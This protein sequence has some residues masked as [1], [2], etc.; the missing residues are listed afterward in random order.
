MRML[1]NWMHKSS[2]DI[3]KN[4]A[5][6]T[7][8]EVLIAASIM[9]VVF[10]AVGKLSLDG[11]RSARNVES[12]ADESDLRMQ[13]NVSLRDPETCLERIQ[14]ANGQTLPQAGLNEGMMK[15]LA[16]TVG[17][18]EIGAAQGSLALGSIRLAQA[19]D[20]QKLEPGKGFGP[21]VKIKTIKLVWEKAADGTLPELKTDLFAKIQ[22]VTDRGDV[23]G[24]RNKTIELPLTLRRADNTDNSPIIGCFVGDAASAAD[25]SPYLV[26]AQTSE[27]GHCIGTTDEPIRDCISRLPAAGGTVYIKSGTYDIQRL[28]SL[29]DHTRL[30][31]SR[32]AVLKLGADLRVGVSTGSQVEVEDIVL[33]SSRVTAD[34]ALSLLVSGSDVRIRNNRFVSETPAT[35][36][37]AIGMNGGVSPTRIDISS[38]RF[39]GHAA[40][41]AGILR[42]TPVSGVVSGQ[43]GFVSIENNEFFDSGSGR[44]PEATAISL[45]STSAFHL[46]VKNNRM[47]QVK[48]GVQIAADLFSAVMV[49]GNQVDCVDGAPGPG[50]LNGIAGSS[51]LLLSDR[52]EGSF[53]GDSYIDIKNNQILHCQTG[54][55]AQGNS[56]SVVSNQL[57]I[58]RAGASL[59]IKV[60][61]SG[62]RI[63]ANAVRGASFGVFHEFPAQGF[64]L[65]RYNSLEIESNRLETTADRINPGGPECGR[66]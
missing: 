27:E 14:T 60:V 22:V 30:I 10:L 6:M 4:R 43:M 42:S 49:E 23:A 31:G 37:S 3:L 15:R 29:P 18:A 11:M 19:P 47:S 56:I 32:D 16:T 17:G 33:D 64:G 24:L 57:L 36:R 20:S 66:T 8:V 59:G 52:S 50:F 13:A 25:K 44:V 5:G 12:Q 65:V 7:I 26:V 61:G 45:D 9:T 28:I 62:T 1:K 54:I 46:S 39:E 63:Q 35:R 34:N 2:R 53:E 38:N 48:V 41:R 51:G 58:D 55:S 40:T 21:R